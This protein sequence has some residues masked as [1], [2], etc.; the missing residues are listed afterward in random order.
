MWHGWRR[1]EIRR[2]LGGEIEGRRP[3]ERLILDWRI[4]LEWIFNK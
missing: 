2:D 3:L 1:E 4:T